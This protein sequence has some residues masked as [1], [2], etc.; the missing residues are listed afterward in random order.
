L[1]I[2]YLTFVSV[3]STLTLQIFLLV[4]IWA[5]DRREEVSTDLAPNVVKML[6]SD[7]TVM[8]MVTLQ[9]K[10]RQVVSA[11]GWEHDPREHP[12]AILGVWLLKSLI[13]HISTVSPKSLKIDVLKKEVYFKE[14]LQYI[15]LQYTSPSLLTF[16]LPYERSFTNL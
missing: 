7:V 13:E 14:A 15:W 12:R 4:G 1:E 3:T 11:V 10:F 2:I 5:R 6:L 8:L 16:D 9:S